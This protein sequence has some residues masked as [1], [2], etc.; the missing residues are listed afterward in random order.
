VKRIDARTLLEQG[1]A[2]LA[3]AR[4]HLD[5]SFHEVTAL[6]DACKGATDKQL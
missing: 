4:R 2:E 5:F 1:L 3:N 6:S